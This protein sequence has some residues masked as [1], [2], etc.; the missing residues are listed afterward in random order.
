MSPKLDSVID[1]EDTIIDVSKFQLNIV[2]FS[3]HLSLTTILLHEFEKNCQKNY[4]L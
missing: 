4:A 3:S 2:F 1:I